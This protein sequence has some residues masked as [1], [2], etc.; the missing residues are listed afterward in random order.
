MYVHI[1]TINV[2]PDVTKIEQCM[3]MESDSIH[4]TLHTTCNVH[5]RFVIGL[6]VPRIYNVVRAV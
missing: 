3:Y 1:A 5:A 2:R 4:Q 6:I